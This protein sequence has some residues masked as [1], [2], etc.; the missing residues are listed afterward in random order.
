MTFESDIKVDAALHI[1]SVATTA[2]M[3]KQ[4]FFIIII[5]LKIVMY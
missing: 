3:I 4:I 5:V 1:N 2:T